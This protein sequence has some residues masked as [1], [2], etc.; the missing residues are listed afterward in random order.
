M[1]VRHGRDEG[2]ILGEGVHPWYADIDADAMARAC[3]DEGLRRVL[4]A[5]A[6]LD[7]V[8]ALDN[9]CWPDPIQSAKTPDGHHKLA[10]LVRCCEGLH[11]ACVAYGVPLISGKDSMKNDAFLGGVKISI[12]PTLLVS[13]MGQTDDVG[14]CLDLEPRAVDERVYLLGP[15]KLE[16]GASELGRALAGRDVTLA[17]TDVP[18]TDLDACLARYRAFVEQRDAGRIRAA[19]VCGRGG[20]A[21]ALA[22]MSLA[23]ERGLELRVDEVACGDGRGPLPPAAALFSESTGRVVLTCRASDAA[24]LERE[25]GPHGL[26]PLGRVT[27]EPRLTA[28]LDGH[29]VVEV[30]LAQLRAGWEEG[31]RGL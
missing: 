6:R 13:V 10:Q 30:S 2:V 8:A 23:S 3:V 16:L 14:R 27:S 22:H 9:F 5:G 18:R 31:L 12:P 21:L 24:T 26:V 19:H 15:T 4:C 25:L 17:D 7:R 1:R 20:L 11:A 29:G 28:E